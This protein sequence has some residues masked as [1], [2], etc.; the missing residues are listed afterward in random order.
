MTRPPNPNPPSI[1]SKVYAVLGQMKPGTRFT[2]KSLGESMGLVAVDKINTIS[3][4]LSKHKN[5]GMYDCRGRL[6][7]T[8]N[9]G[10]SLIVYEMVDPHVV[11]KISK[12]YPEGVKKTVISRAFPRDR[13]LPIVT[14]GGEPEP[15]SD[16]DQRVVTPTPSFKPLVTVDSP[17]KP[18]PKLAPAVVSSLVEQAL[19]LTLE[20]E[21]WIRNPDRIKGFSTSELEAEINRRKQQE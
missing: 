3:A 8:G 10:S 19:A 21:R 12:H 15:H 4:F 13:H 11:F 16:K 6:R 17:R 20:I 7:R 18:D 1:S 14:M 2:S 9:N 5:G